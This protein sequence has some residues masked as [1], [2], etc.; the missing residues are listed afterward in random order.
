M[1]EPLD[2][3]VILGFLRGWRKEVA[4]I[5]D[6][7]SGETYQV[8]PTPQKLGSIISAEHWESPGASDDQRCRLNS[9]ILREAPPSEL[10]RELTRYPLA[11]GYWYQVIVD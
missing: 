5:H 7:I 3:D 4:A 1:S 6:P 10:L 9:R 11:P 2:T 8:F